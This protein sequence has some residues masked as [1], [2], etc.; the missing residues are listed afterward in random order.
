KAKIQKVHVYEIK[1]AD[2]ESLQAIL[3]GMFPAAGTSARTSTNRNT[4]T[5]NTSSTGN[6]SGNTGNT[7]T[8]G[9]G[10]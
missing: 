8:R 2:A 10:R 5:R 3:Q 7:G 9:G 4:R 6:R 1:D